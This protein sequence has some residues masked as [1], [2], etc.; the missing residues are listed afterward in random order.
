MVVPAGLGAWSKRVRAE[1]RGGGGEGILGWQYQPTPGV[2]LEK[3]PQ[4]RWLHKVGKEDTPG[5][6][7]QSQMEQSGKHIVE[8]YVKLTELKLRREVEKEQKMGVLE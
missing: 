5:C 3:G 2:S 7:C 8:E 1:A 6:H 4:R